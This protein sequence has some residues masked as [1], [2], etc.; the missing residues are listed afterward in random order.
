MRLR[1]ITLATLLLVM[2]ISD[3]LAQ[4]E[5]FRPLVFIPGILGTELLD[6][7]NKVVWGDSSS[8]RNFEKLELGRESSQLH[9]GG[10]VK[11]I[12]ILGPFWTIHQYDG[13][14]SLLK[15]LNY[16]EG[17]NFFVFC[18]DW[19]LSN[20]DNEVKLE[21]FIKQNPALNGKDIDIL[22]HS[23]GGLIA[24]LYLHQSPVAVYVKR[25]I[26]LAVPSRGSMN[27]L[28]EM[29]NGWGGFENFVAGGISTIRRVMFSFPSVFELFP[30]YD[31]CCRIGKQ[32][33]QNFEYFDPTDSA[34][35][36]L[37]DWIPPEHRS[38]T[39]LANVVQSLAN[40]RKLK[41][42][43]SEP[44]PPD[45]EQ[46]IVAGDRFAT[47]LYLY[48]DPQ[49]RSWSKWQFSKSGG[50]G[51]VPLWSAAASDWPGRSLPAFV[52][53]ATIF[54]D[55]WVQNLLERILNKNNTPP[56]MAATSLALAATRSNRLVEVSLVKLDPE[57]VLLSPGGTTKVS[58]AITTVDPLAKGEL[59]PELTVDGPSGTRRV[60]LQ[61]LTAPANLND[62]TLIFSGDIAPEVA[63]AYSLHLTIP[64]LSGAYTRDIVALE[65]M[66]RM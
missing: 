64:G 9:A 10:L 37:G 23:M 57:L 56:P 13:L 52:D 3:A 36:Q 49:D 27:S 7:N 31:H 17:Q 47:D 14:F 66:G 20:F 18:Y 5:P 29:T 15:D 44:L 51:T 22:A 21:E 6:Q 63:G 38:G 61:E 16:V 48:V 42:I 2:A 43:L 59:S 54:E 53:H 11:Q 39:Q 28:A 24:K 50:D 33:E 60:E 40:A 30:S 34:L 8:L 4:P 26:S 62:R 55:K 32:G 45:L 35:W 19:R 1:S 58:V 41:L 25:L 65:P 46:T 12:N